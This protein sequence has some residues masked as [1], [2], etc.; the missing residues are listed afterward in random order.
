M[1]DWIQPRGG[2]GDLAAKLYAQPCKI[3]YLGASV[4]VQRDGYLP[5]LHQALV[6]A[7]GQ[8]HTAINASMGAVGSGAAVFTM[9]SRVLE[10]SPDFCFVELSTGDMGHKTPLPEIGPALEGIVRKL[11]DAGCPVCFL[12]L[13]RSDRAFGDT[14]PVLMPY[15]QVA[16][17]YGIPSLNVGAQMEAEVRRGKYAVSDLLRDHVHTTPRGADITAAL[18]LQ[19]VETLWAHTPA[20]T[21]YLERRALPNLFP[22]NFHHTGIVP[23][24]PQMLREPENFVRGKFRLVLDFIQIDSH[25]EIVWK[26]DGDLVGMQL[27]LGK[28]SGVIEVVTPQATYTYALWDPDCYY[29]RVG[30]KI[31]YP[32]IPAHTPVRIR[33]TEQPIDYSVSRRPI[34]NTE[35]IQKNLKVLSFMV[36]L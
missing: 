1:T 24:T 8:L 20:E 19:G 11:Q 21:N 10:H 16:A 34:E 14:N 15:E 28:E 3:A 2:F 36:R 7:T 31:I 33:L 32:F 5:R 29:D 13:Y 6:T 17:Y 35:A 9:D 25:N 27:I 22:K 12:Y 18:I 30:S 26:F 4:S 23:L